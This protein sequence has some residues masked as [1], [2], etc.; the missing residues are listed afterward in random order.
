MMLRFK[1]KKLTAEG[2]KRRYDVEAFVEEFYLSGKAVA[3]IKLEEA[4]SRDISNGGTHAPFSNAAKRLGRP[5]AVIV[6]KGELYF[7]N[8]EKIEYVEV[9]KE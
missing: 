1:S 6:R 2:K 9:E 3:R 8:M 5:I 7:I 4:Y